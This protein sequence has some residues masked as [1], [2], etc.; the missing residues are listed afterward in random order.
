VQSYTHRY[1][2]VVPAAYHLEIN[3]VQ[4][5]GIPNAAYD[6]NAFF[7]SP[8][9]ASRPTTNFSVTLGHV[10]SN[11]EILC[12]KKLVLRQI[13]LRIVRSITGIGFQPVVLK[14]TGWKPIP[15]QKSDIY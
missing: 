7:A 3:L 14:M 8:Q 12:K 1:L 11:D 4:T 5:K 6:A 10:W 2:S 13:A 15:L 9:Q